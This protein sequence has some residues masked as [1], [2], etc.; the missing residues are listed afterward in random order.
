MTKTRTPFKT[1]LFLLPLLFVQTAYGDLDSDLLEAAKAG[2]TAEV[3]K[4]LEKGADV[5]AR[6]EHGATALMIA[7][8]GGHV[9]VVETLIAEGAYAEGGEGASALMLA[10]GEDHAEVVKTLIAE[11]ADVNA[12]TGDGVTVLMWMAGGGHA[13]VVKTLI[14]KGADVNAPRRRRF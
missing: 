5:S 7:A 10:A 13:E 14:A 9:E 12:R 6:S 3:K 8:G 2:D 4:L 11:G 1:I